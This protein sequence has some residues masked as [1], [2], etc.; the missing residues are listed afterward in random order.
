MRF[1]VWNKADDALGRALQNAAV[2]EK[3][4]FQKTA[5]VPL[6]RFK[7]A[8][9]LEKLAAKAKLDESLKAER[10]TW[11]RRRAT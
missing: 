3:L 1:I 5:Q 4:L 11:Q 9:V 2:S 7:Q 8:E 10:E 6:E